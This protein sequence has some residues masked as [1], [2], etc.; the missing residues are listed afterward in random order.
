MQ[1]T[2]HFNADRLV[3]PLACQQQIHGMIYRLLSA[4]PVFSEALHNAPETARAFKGFTFSKL[5]G[6]YQIKGKWFEFNGP[7][8]LEIRSCQEAVIRILQESLQKGEPPRLGSNILQLTD[9]EVTDRHI[10][11]SL[12]RVRMNTPIAV[13]R[14]D[15]DRH[16]VFYSPADEA[17]CPAVVRNAERKYTYLTGHTPAQ[18]LTV[19]PLFTDLPKKL[20]T[21][22]KGTYIT[23]WFGDYLLSSTPDMLDFLYQTGLGS[24]NSEGFGLFNL[25]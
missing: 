12:I 8:S 22:F 5:N 4:H 20:C 7:V 21:V 24:K 11:D 25:L 9:V 16:T 6:V 17:F 2:I 1:M 18:P 10:A 15:E 23:G 19:Q 13:Y 3:L 14:T